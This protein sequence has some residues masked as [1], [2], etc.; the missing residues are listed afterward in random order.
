M[1]AKTQTA[2]ALTGIGAPLEKINLPIPTPK[3]DQVLLKIRATGLLPFDMK[4]AKYGVLDIGKHLPAVLG[5]DVVGEVVSL[6]SAVTHL[7][8]GQLV[9]SQSSMSDFQ[10]G[11]LQQYT[12]LDAKWCIPVP[13]NL[14]AVEASAFP[15]NAFT[16]AVA[17]FGPNGLRIP[18]PF[19]EGSEKADFDYGNV[20]LVIIGGGTNNGQLAIQFSRLAGFGTIIAVGG[21]EKAK[22]LGATHVVDRTLSEEEIRKSVRDVVGDELLYV[23]DTFS[24]SDISLG[25]SMLSNT[26]KG[27][28]VQLGFAQVQDQKIADEKQAGF[29]VR[30]T[31]GASAMWPDF[32]E[33][34]WPVFCKWVENGDV[35]KAR[36]GIIDGLDE[37][38]IN[39]AID[40][41]ANGSV[42]VG[43]WAVQVSE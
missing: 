12:A 7:K 11:G 14:S 28:L 5:I 36:V 40:E 24:Q 43:K 32:A 31:F 33:V 29:D 22:S 13:K 8:V 1:S 3:D 2:I 9:F 18:F 39:T 17:I 27:T 34:F 19:A 25:V 15:V 10:S 16:S 37:K 42:K 41:Y 35:Q 21:G 4:F 23:L 6:G 30:G 20:K 26:K 38:A